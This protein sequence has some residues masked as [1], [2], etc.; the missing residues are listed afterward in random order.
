MHVS[1]IYAT[2]RQTDGRR[3]RCD[4]KVQSKAVAGSGAAVLH[5]VWHTMIRVFRSVEIM[6]VREICFGKY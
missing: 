4:V 2:D 1:E 5:N 3:Y 6:S